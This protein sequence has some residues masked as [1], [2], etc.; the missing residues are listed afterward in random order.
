MMA[1]CGMLVASF[2][3]SFLMAFLLFAVQPMATKMVLPVLGGTPAVWTTAMLTF[4]LLL[5]AGYAYAHALV[6]WASPRAQRLIHTALLLLTAFQ[7]PLWI[8]LPADESLLAH[9]IAHLLRAFLLQAGLPFLAI[10]A[11]APLMQSWVSRST[12]PLADKPYVLY[13]ASNLGS[14]AG[15]FGY[16]GLVEPALDLSQQSWWWMLLFFAGAASLIALGFQLRP[17]A[18]NPIISGTAP[19]PAIHTR[20]RWLLL[21]FLPSSLSLGVTTYITTDIASMP[22]LWVIPLALYLLSFVDAFRATPFLVPLAQRLAPLLSL[23]SLMLIAL[24]VSSIAIFVFHLLSFAVLALALH[25]WLAQ[26]RPAAA[27]LTHYYLLLSVGGALGGILNGAL[28]PMVFPDAMEYPLALLAAAIVTFLARQRDEQPGDTLHHLLRQMR[29]PVLTVVC[30]TPPIYLLL[31][32]RQTVPGLPLNSLLIAHSAAFAGIAGLL[33]NRSFRGAYVSA[34]VVVV[35]VT[36]AHLLGVVG[37]DVLFRDRNFFGVSKVLENR[38]LQ[39]RYYMHDTTIHGVQSL[40][41]GESTRALAYYAPL[42]E[43][44]AELPQTHRG[45]LGVVG[46]GIGTLK[47]TAQP[48][49]QVDLFEINPMAQQ[50]AEDATLFTYMRDCPGKSRVLLGDGRIGLQ[51]QPDGRY[52]A[53]ILDAFSS[54]A[55]PSHLLTLEALTL[56]RQKLT[57]TGVLLLNTTNRHLNLW[58]LLAAQAKALHLVA[59]GKFFRQPE[60]KKLLFNSFWVVLAQHRAD[61]TPLLRQSADWQEL[62]DENQRPWT[63]SY[64]SILPLLKMRTKIPPSSPP[65]A[66]D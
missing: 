50:L 37:F 32:W 40:R 45:S 13:S 29:R 62:A 56:Y 35:F 3:I 52:G 6:R 47:C 42:R 54:D 39:S 16:V 43:V 8:T 5:L 58:P 36:L 1:R 57:P 53:I 9:P 44:L 33:L 18:M 41:P 30:F 31:C 38:A 11:T 27:H 64:T 65:P 66:R 12:H 17:A 15:L 10:S 21:A 7:L 63:D 34:M 28:A 48:K 23:C 24:G 49:Q 2:S 26:A 61:I 59:Y 46:L 22:L 19:P 55:I 20:L 4:Q 51:Q 25:G 60:E 14:F